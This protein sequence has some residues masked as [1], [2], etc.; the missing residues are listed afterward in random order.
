MPLTVK[1]ARVIAG[2]SRKEVAK[3]LNLSVEGYAK[4]ERG[5]S[6]FYIDEIVTLSEILKVDMQNFFEVQCHKKTRELLKK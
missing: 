2:L 6:K 1:T 3:K 4:K 5:Q